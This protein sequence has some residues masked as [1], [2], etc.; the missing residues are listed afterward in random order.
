MKIRDAMVGC[1]THCSYHIKQQEARKEKKD[2]I[3]VS[4]SF[5]NLFSKN[6]IISSLSKSESKRNL[7]DLFLTLA[8]A[9]VALLQIEPSSLYKLAIY[10]WLHFQLYFCFLKPKYSN[11]SIKMQTYKRKCKFEHMPHINMKA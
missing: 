8:H 11:Q 3:A 5:V 4:C 1:Q 2:L 10:H 9:I 7:N 6:Y